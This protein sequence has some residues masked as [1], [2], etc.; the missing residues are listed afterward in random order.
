MGEDTIRYV[1][2]EKLVDKG[3]VLDVG[4]GDGNFAKILER[5]G[6]QVIGCDIDPELVKKAKQGI[7]AFVCNVEKEELPRGNFDYITCIDVIEHVIDPVKLLNNLRGKSKY[8]VITTPNACWLADRLKILGGN[9][10]RHNAYQMGQHLWYW[11]Y[12]QF[13]KFLQENDFEILDEQI[14]LVPK[15]PVFKNWFAYAYAFKLKNTH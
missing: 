10:S 15:I 12:S 4:C 8:I 3:K 13:K 2:A 7:E 11:S 14:K 5:R 9:V 1:L 6:C